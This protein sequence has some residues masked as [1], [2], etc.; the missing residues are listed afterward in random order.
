VA[1]KA[2]EGVWV[3][4]VNSRHA[5]NRGREVLAIERSAQQMS[6][7]CEVL[8][9]RTEARQEALRALRVA[10]AS[11]APLAFPRGLVAVLRTVVE[12]G[13][14]LDENVLHV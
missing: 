8:R 13:R 3:T 10:K 6:L 14:C 4:S 9:D 11:H 2:L 1:Q 7:Q 12:A 5:T